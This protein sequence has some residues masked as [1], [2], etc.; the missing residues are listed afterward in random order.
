MKLTEYERGKKS[1]LS[2][3]PEPAK[4]VIKPKP[5]GADLSPTE[6]ARRRDLVRAAKAIHKTNRETGKAV[7]ICHTSVGEWLRGEKPVI[8]KHVPTL[9]AIAHDKRRVAL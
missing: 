3:F 6:Q 9:E 8:D 2:Y 7:G 5:R 1:P 4:K